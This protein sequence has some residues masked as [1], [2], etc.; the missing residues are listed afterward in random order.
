QVRQVQA[1]DH[2]VQGTVTS[3]ENLN[4]D[5][6]RLPLR[7]TSDADGRF[8]LDGLPGN[9]RIAL[10][11]ADDRFIRKTV[12]AATTATAQPDLVVGRGMSRDG[13]IRTRPEPVHTGAFTVALQPGHRLRVR[14]VGAAAGKPVAGARISQVLGTSALEGN[15]A[16]DSDGRL[17]FSPLAP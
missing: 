6:S 11:V 12:Y 3:A 7:T 5:G 16:T 10:S 15:Q 4:V 14:V 17:S 1:L 8:V 9:M 13:G 2:P